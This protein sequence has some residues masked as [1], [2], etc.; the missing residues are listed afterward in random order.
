MCNDYDRML[1]E[2]RALERE[3]RDEMGADDGKD[4]HDPEVCPECGGHMREI[5]DN[6]YGSDADGRRGMKVRWLECARCEYVP[7]E[8]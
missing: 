2:E 8:Q 5:T 1:D 3:M 7:K 6:N 4:A